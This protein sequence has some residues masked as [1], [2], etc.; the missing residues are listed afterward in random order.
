MDLFDAIH[1]RRSIRSY[2]P[3]PVEAEKLTRVLE[4]ARQAPSAGNLEAFEIVVVRDAAIR[5]RLA[6][7]ALGQKFIAQAPVVLVFCADTRRSAAAYGERGG[8]LYCVQDATIAASFAWLAATALGLG[9]V[10]IGAFDEAAVGA[11][12][13]AP[14]HLRPVAIL[15]VGYPAEEAEP[16]AR[17][18]LAELVRD[19]RY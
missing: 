18:S 6:R 9:S 3:K 1:E 13:A 16:S 15:P 10:W 14:P 4:S 8:S 12:L 7:A 2:H 19:D 17:R 5:S 11:L